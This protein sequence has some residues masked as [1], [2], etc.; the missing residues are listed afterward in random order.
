MRNGRKEP[1][2]ER[3]KEIECVTGIRFKP[4]LEEVT[5]DSRYRKLGSNSDHEY[6]PDQ[7]E[8]FPSHFLYFENTLKSLKH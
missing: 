6:H 3:I 8:K 7:I 1:A 4:L 2:G 5:V